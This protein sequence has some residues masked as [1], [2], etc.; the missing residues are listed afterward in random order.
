V[1]GVA[2][3][4]RLDPSDRR[5]HAAL[6]ERLVCLLDAARLELA[7]DRGLR[8]V[9]AGDHEQ[10]AR[11]PVEAVDD[12]RSLDAGDPAPLVARSMGQ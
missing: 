7:H 12:A 1:L 4:R 8:H 3:D 10:A 11:V 9:V 2:T 5:R 6:D